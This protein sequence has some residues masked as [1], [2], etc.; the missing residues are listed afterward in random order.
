[1][2][3]PVEAGPVCAAFDGLVPAAG[4]FEGDVE[5]SSLPT[6]AVPGAGCAAGALE[7]EDLDGSVE[8]DAWGVDCAHTVVVSANAN[9]ASAPAVEPLKSAFM[10]SPPA[11]RRPSGTAPLRSIV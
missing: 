6:G 11:R 1:M 7:G 10:T 8:E 5:A 2:G 3:A 4:G 9:P